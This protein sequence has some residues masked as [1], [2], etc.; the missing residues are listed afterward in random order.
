MSHENEATRQRGRGVF[1]AA[2]ISLGRI[3]LAALDAM[4][5]SKF[6]REFVL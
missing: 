6:P 5:T 4:R 1:A 2:A 3:A